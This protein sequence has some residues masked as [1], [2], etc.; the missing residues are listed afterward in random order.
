L[1]FDQLT[2]LLPHAGQAFSFSLFMLQ[3]V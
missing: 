3:P 2:R 1:G